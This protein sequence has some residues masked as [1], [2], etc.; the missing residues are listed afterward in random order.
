MAVLGVLNGASDELVD[1]GPSITFGANA[2]VRGLN[3]WN[4]T[5]HCVQPGLLAGHED[6]LTDMV[7]LA[8]AQGVQLDAMTLD[9]LE[10]AIWVKNSP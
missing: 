6:L 5:K 2:N 10:K 8:S 1:D 4:D 7:L 3:G 9:E